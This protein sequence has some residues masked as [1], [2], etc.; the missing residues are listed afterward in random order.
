M[1][2]MLSYV[3]LLP[4]I[5][6]I[7]PPML[8]AIPKPAEPAVRA[9]IDSLKTGKLVTLTLTSGKKVKGEVVSKADESLQLR[10]RR[11]FFKHREETYPIANVVA[12]KTHLPSWV[13]PV[14]GAGI[15]GGIVVGVVA[16]VASGACLN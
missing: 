1:K 8:F 9:T 3:L 2:Q 5:G 14:I 11:G 15:V 16:C 10:V 12:V 7:A 6:D 4:L 13:G